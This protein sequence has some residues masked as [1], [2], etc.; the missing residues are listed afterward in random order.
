MLLKLKV[1][2]F[3]NQ[4]VVV[5]IGHVWIEFEPQEAGKGFEFEN[6]IVGGCVPREYIACS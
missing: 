6:K 3:V 5:N 4:V 1:S 2:S